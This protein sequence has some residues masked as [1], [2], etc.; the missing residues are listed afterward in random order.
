MSFNLK[1]IFSIVISSVLFFGC[2]TKPEEAEITILYTTDLHG[3][4]LPYDFNKDKEATISL[5]NVKHYVDEQRGKNK[6]G[7]LLLDGGDFLQGQPSLYY[8][9]FEDTISKHL[10]ARVMEYVGYE[11]ATVGN[12]DIEP[13]EEVYTRVQKD[14]NFP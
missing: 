5:A 1:N 9:N 6:D 13:G 8:S 10:Q 3:A 7:I 14:F 4:V 11:G 2:K 12:H